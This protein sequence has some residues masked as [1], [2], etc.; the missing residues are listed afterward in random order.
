MKSDNGIEISGKATLWPED[1]EQA[2]ASV[3]V[4]PRNRKYS[5]QWLSLWQ[6]VETGVTLM[7]QA[8]ME[9][10]LTQTEYRVRDFLL[11]SIGLGNWALVNQAEIARQLRL[12]RPN[13][14]KAIERL[15]ELGIVIKGE[16]LGRN[17]QYMISA[18]FCFKGGLGAG[19]K[20]V[21]KAQSQHKNGKILQFPVPEL[22]QGSLLPE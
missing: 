13:V 22:C 5:V 1:E 16:K 7:E 10:P 21:Q 17:A 8:K 14:S 19:Q 11:A 18:G 3:L 15:I 20:L 6:N 2:P 9:K 12:H 4:V